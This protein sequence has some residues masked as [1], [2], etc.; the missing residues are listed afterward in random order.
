MTAFMQMQHFQADGLP[1]AAKFAACRG[2]QALLQVNAI[3]S[4]GVHY[5]PADSSFFNSRPGQ[6]QAI[7]LM[8]V[9]GPLQAATR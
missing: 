7:L 9:S 3:H 1:G 8:P 2:C 4:A 5:K 6:M